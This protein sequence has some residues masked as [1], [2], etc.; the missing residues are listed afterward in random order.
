AYVPRR[1][2][3]LFALALTVAIAPLLPAAPPVALLSVQSLIIAAQQLLVGIACGLLLQLVFDA[4]GLGGQLLANSMGLSFAFNVDPQR[5]AATPALGQFYMV[6]VTLT[7]VTLDGHLRMI[8]LLFASFA[9]LPIGTDG[10]GAAGLSQWLAAAA[11]LFE[12]ALRV[13]LPGLT[14]LLIVNISFGVL[15]RAAPA[16]NLFAVG[17]PL[18]LLLGLLAVLISLPV[19]QSA[20]LAVADR[21]FAAVDRIL[22]AGV[23]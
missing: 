16:L 21:A 14:A 22:A 18:A 7:F 2:R 1:V 13:A 20:F 3:L 15:S 9:Q 19:V 23:Q 4:I 6:L 12:G 8:E 10:I 17:F 11:L 5:G